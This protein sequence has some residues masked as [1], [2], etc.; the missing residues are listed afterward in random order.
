MITGEQQ[1]PN[2]QSGDGA[3]PVKRDGEPKPEV[4][5]AA[6]GT[7]YKPLDVA[8]L[9]N[10]P[11]E[12]KDGKR[13]VCWREEIRN[14]E[15][16][17]VPV[18]PHTGNRAKSNNRATWGTFDEATAFFQAHRDKLQGVGRM[19]DAEV[20]IMGVDF[21][22]CL[23]HYGNVISSH[24]AA[25]WLSRLD[26]HS[27]ISPSGRGVKV[28][29]R[30]AHDLD[31]KTGRHDSKLGVEIYREN[32]F[33]TLTGQRLE[34]FKGNV[35]VRQHVIDELYREVFGAKEPARTQPEASTSTALN[36]LEIINRVSNAK[37]GPKFKALWAGEID[38]YG[39]R[40]EADAALCSLLWFWTGNLE[41]VRQLFGQSALGQRDKW[42]RRDYQESTL[43]LACKGEVYS[44]PDGM[45]AM[46]ADPRPKVRLPGDDWLLSVT[47][48]ELGQHLADKPIFVHN[49]EIVTSDGTDLHSVTPQT[50]RTLVERHVVCYRKRRAGNASFEVKIT[51]SDDDARGIMASPQ[52]RERLRRVRR[53]NSCRLPVLRVNGKLELLSEGYDSASGTLTW[54]GVAY[55]EDMTLGVAVET[56]NDLFGEFCFADSKRSK[57]VAVAALVGLYAAQ[58]LP[59]GALRPCF[60]VTKNAEGAGAG[61]LVSCAVVPVIGSVPTG[62]KSDSDDEMRK[63]LTAAVREARL[64]LL[65][66]NLKGRLSSAALEAFISSATWC[67]RL[68]GVN[69]NI[70]APNIATV[71]VTANGCTITPDMRR[72]SLIVELHLE[73][74]R[75]EDREFRRP[76]DLPTLLALR[77]KILAACWSLV[78]HWHS[79][80][81]PPPS[82]S[83]SAFPAWAKIIGGIVQV[84]GF[85]CPLDTAD[86]AV[87]ADEDGEAMRTLVE[88]MQPSKQYTFSEIVEL[89]RTIDCFG[90]LV[91][92]SELKNSS[93]VT[94]ARLL[95]RYHRRLVKDRRFVFEGQGHKR[96]YFVETVGA[97]ARS[98]DPHAVSVQAGESQYA[99]TDQKSM[100]SVSS[101]R[102]LGSIFS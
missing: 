44:P 72:R 46:L 77:P 99:G 87:A 71:F 90:G 84:A 15:P 49:G 29:V 51:M 86:V 80:G 30:A 10:V 43:T 37:N 61:T 50:F 85:A 24:P 21:D 14:G 33:F 23:D 41:H 9:D 45:Q 48:E 88:A 93:R 35:E 96:R 32:R 64:V 74:E 82:R 18:N 53:L 3:C 2:T 31:G 65:F 70:T 55:P 102:M 79:Q 69:E 91:G 20:G 8:Q 54:S 47:A 19:L 83:H 13:L 36:D 89:C 76:L 1:R 68:L 40:S 11:E 42:Q 63:V 59:D 27:E 94:L 60:I 95:G 28:W 66:D 16:T 25:R 6:A 98:H 7:S 26:S 100:L 62:V 17:K 12:L 58:L 34:Q 56:I 22:D 67:D 39:S 92:D 52:F 75:A 78:R 81:Q 38:G 97:N 5:A 57:A 73:V 4:R 101:V